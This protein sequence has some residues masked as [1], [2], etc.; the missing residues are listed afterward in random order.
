MCPACIP[1][2]AI[3]LFGLTSTSGLAALVMTKRT[4]QKDIDT[5]ET[6]DKKVDE[7]GQGRRHA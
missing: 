6:S 2:I 4:T 5:S 3:V 1:H 7:L